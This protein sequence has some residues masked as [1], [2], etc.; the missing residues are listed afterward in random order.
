[1]T[2]RAWKPLQRVLRGWWPL[3]YAGYRWSE[4]KFEGKQGFENV[5]KSPR[6]AGFFFGY[7]NKLTV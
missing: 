1:V 7:I 3:V 2:E 4:G 5:K 6:K